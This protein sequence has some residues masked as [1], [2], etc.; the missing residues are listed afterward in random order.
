MLRTQ[1]ENERRGRKEEVEA[2]MFC[3]VN[4]GMSSLQFIEGRR[5]VKFWQRVNVERQIARTCAT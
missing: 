3:C 4:D 1:G 2:N 5:R